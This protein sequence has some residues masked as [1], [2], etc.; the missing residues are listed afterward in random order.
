MEALVGKS[1]PF[2]STSMALAC[3]SWGAVG[4]TYPRDASPRSACGLTCLPWFYRK[5]TPAS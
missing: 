3:G 1:R 2:Y 5:S 4:N